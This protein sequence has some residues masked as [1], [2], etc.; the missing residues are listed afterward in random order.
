MV[1]ILF[2]GTT[3]PLGATLK[4]FFKNFYNKISISFQFYCGIKLARAPGRPL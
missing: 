1:E 4:K 2:K 3:G